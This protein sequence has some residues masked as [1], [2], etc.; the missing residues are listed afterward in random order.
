MSYMWRREAAINGK[1]TT[2]GKLRSSILCQEVSSRVLS[3][4]VQLTQIT[5]MEHFP[6]KLSITTTGRKVREFSIWMTLSSIY[7]ETND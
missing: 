1:S 7:L 6:V 4:C 3:N 5:L 2:G